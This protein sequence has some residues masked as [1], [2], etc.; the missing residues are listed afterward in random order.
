MLE[1][2]TNSNYLRN[3]LSKRPKRTLCGKS[4]DDLWNENKTSSIS[5][6][7]MEN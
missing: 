4:G 6:K 3:S 1:C 2:L 7:R 5:V